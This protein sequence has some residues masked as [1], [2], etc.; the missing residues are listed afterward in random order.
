[1]SKVTFFYCTGTAFGI[2]MFNNALKV[3]GPTNYIWGDPSVNPDNQPQVGSYVLGLNGKT[4]PWDGAVYNDPFPFMLNSDVWEP[5]RVAY[6]DAA[7][8]FFEAGQ[9][10]GGMG[11]SINDGVSKVLAKINALPAGAPFAIGGYSQGAAVM[12]EIYNQIKNSGGSLNSRASSFLGGVVFGNP[13]RQLDHRGEIGGTWSGAWDVAG[14]TTGGHGSFPAT[15]PWARLSG[16]D[17]TKWIEFANPKDI[18]SSTGDSN[19][20]IRWSQGNEA[21]LGLQFSQFAGTVLLDAV[22]GAL[23]FGSYKSEIIAAIQTAFTLGNE[24]NYLADP[25]GLIAALGGGGHV[26][27]PNLP[28]PNSSG[29]IP[30]IPTT[31][32]TNYTKTGSVTDV[33]TLKPGTGRFY[34]GSTANP[35][36]SITRTYLKPNGDT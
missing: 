34:Q 36:R 32:T 2:S 13:R 8:T 21:L 16:C 27:Y 5:V 30:S 20:G 14:S 28:P 18:F 26:L 7:A 17:P 1:M 12:S 24:L 29:V 33:A 15:G 11:A 19:T 23:S 31:V 10:V 6:A 22:L 9:V 35:S 4:F 3:Q 25:T